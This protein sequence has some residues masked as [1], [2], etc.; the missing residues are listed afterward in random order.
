[1]WR[2]GLWILVIIVLY[3]A[4]YLPYRSLTAVYAKKVETEISFLP[5]AG[6]LKPLKLGIEGVLSDVLWLKAI[7][8]INTHLDY[9]GPG[10]YRQLQ[11]IY[12]AITDLDPYFVNGY[13]Y[14]AL[15]LSVLGRKHDAAIA[16]LKKGLTVPEVRKRW[17]LNYDLGAMYFLEKHDFDKAAEYFKLAALDENAPAFVPYVASYFLKVTQKEHGLRLSLNL[18]ERR[19]ESKNKEVRRVARQEIVKLKIELEREQHLT[20]LKRAAQMFKQIAGRWPSDLTEFLKP[21]ILGKLPEKEAAELFENTTGRP[22]KN[23]E[24]LLTLSVL[25]KLPEEPTG[26]SYYI[27]P[28]TGAVSYKENRENL[29]KAIDEALK[30]VE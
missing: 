3:G 24:E 27:D 8:Y 28:K 25:R 16:L 21:G 6:A 9:R 15:F 12:E 22:P 23:R 17:E 18:W 19:L 7:G 30:D 5:R 20:L 13:R 29:L 11:A 4:S 10:R 26:G 1:M 2:K 14:G